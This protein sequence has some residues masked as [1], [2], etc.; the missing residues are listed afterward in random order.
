METIAK[1]IVFAKLAWESF[2]SGTCAVQG[3]VLS[4]RCRTCTSSCLILLRLTLRLSIS[5]TL[6]DW[7]VGLRSAPFRI[8][9]SFMRAVTCSESSLI[10]TLYLSGWRDWPCHDCLFFI[11]SF[12]CL[13]QACWRGARGMSTGALPC[14][15]WRAP[16]Q[17][18]S[19]LRVRCSLD[20]R[21]QNELRC[22]C[23]A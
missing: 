14:R 16:Y 12:G 13:T 23:Q 18:F 5:V 1:S 7:I 11:G 6:W 3:F 21:A 10:H 17:P 15:S 8:S 22:I 19:L 2:A 4:R 20:R 9:S